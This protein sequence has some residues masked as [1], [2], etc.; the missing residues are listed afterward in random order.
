MAKKRTRSRKKSTDAVAS[1]NDDFPTL[2]DIDKAATPKRK[3]SSRSKSKDADAVADDPAPK[4]RSRVEDDVDSRDNDRGER[5][6][7][8][9]DEKSDGLSL[10]HI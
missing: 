6:S 8:N 5:S 9:S 1:K 2:D 3:R 7:K 10:I 4:S